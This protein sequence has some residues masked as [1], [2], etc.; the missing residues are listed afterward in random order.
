MNKIVTN[1]IYRHFKGGIYKVQGISIHTENKNVMVNYR[2]I[3][4]HPAVPNWTRPI[5][6][7]NDEV[8]FN[9][10]TVPRFELMEEGIN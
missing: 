4:A 8:V 3:D 10:L 2:E 9:G 7:F 5:E 1:G 6:M